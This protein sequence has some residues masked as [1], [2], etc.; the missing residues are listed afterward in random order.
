MLLLLGDFLLVSPWRCVGVS[1]VGD[2]GREL[3]E[4]QGRITA[5]EP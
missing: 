3:A 1:L 4:K 5:G 2:H